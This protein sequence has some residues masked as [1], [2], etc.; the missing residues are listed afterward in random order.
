MS[1]RHFPDDNEIDEWI[2]AHLLDETDAASADPIMDQLKAA[3][4][5]SVGRFQANA[6]GLVANGLARFA[7]LGAPDQDRTKIRG[8]VRQVMAAMSVGILPLC[9]HVQQIRPLV[10]I[11]DPPV[12]VCTSCLPSRIDVIEALGH[13]WDHECDRCGVHVKMLSATTTAGLGPI[14]VSGHVCSRCA[15]EDERR[16]FQN[17]DQVVLVGRTGNRRARRRGRR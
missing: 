1:A 15:A 13:R 8:T 14:T 7:T 6:P 3:T 17:V 12:I 5:D 9:S 4:A 2:G 10:L 11:C 16:A